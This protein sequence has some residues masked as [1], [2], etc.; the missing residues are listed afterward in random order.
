M[1]CSKTR[2]HCIG[3]R[4][5]RDIAAIEA[6]RST[7][8]FAACAPRRSR[9]PLQGCGSPQAYRTRGH[10]RAGRPSAP[11]ARR[12]ADGATRAP[13]RTSPRDLPA[14]PGAG[15]SRD[16]LKSRFRDFQGRS[17][18]TA[19]HSNPSHLRATRPRRSLNPSADGYVPGRW[20]VFS[21]LKTIPASAS[22][23]SGGNRCHLICPGGEGI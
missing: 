22:S 13:V 14:K 15:S 2:P 17:Q 11:V 18:T 7:E 20:P 16:D 5:R 21:W 19:S 9:R 4:T 23:Q 12:P 3:A 6:C 10:E 8:P 1:T